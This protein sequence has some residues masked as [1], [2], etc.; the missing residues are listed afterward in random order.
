MSFKNFESTF[1]QE[2]IH[3]AGALVEEPEEDHIEESEN[4]NKNKDFLLDE[5]LAHFLKSENRTN[6]LN[7]VLQR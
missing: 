4:L 2:G 1:Q 5:R 6:P 3:V 7:E